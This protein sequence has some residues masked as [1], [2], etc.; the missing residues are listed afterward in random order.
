MTDERAKSNWTLADSTHLLLLGA[1][2]VVSIALGLK[3]G[4]LS[5]MGPEESQ[6]LHYRL[7]QLEHEQ[8]ATDRRLRV[9][10]DSVGQLL[11]DRVAE[12]AEKAARPASLE[13]RVRALE[14]AASRPR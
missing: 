7:D 4:A 1:T 14:E 9:L 11:V 2:C 5:R 3:L 10:E 6:A 13:E 8:E 12:K